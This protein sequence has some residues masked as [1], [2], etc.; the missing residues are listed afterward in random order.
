[1][2]IGLDI[3]LERFRIVECRFDIVNVEK[4]DRGASRLVA[5]D[6]AWYRLL[7]GIQPVDH[8]GT[9]WVADDRRWRRSFVSGQTEWPYDAR[10][11][12]NA[13]DL[14]GRPYRRIGK[15]GKRLT[16]E[17]VVASVRRDAPDLCGENA[18]FAWE[19]D[20]LKG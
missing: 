14:V 7:P 19:V 18:W 5:A 11:Q 9:E 12:G 3:K 6:I 10:H 2:T 8:V 15:E 1:M 20:V 17:R 16:V 13:A 4:Q